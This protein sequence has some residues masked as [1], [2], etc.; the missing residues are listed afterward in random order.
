MSNTVGNNP[1]VVQLGSPDGRAD[2]A[3]FE[4]TLQVREIGERLS[5][6]EREAAIHS[7][8]GQQCEI[9]SPE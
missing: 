7:S 2:R 1:D 4:L 9:A 3:G 6:D 8:Q 5:L